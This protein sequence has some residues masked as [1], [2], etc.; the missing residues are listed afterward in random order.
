M[1]EHGAN[2][3][4]AIRHV[5]VEPASRGGLPPEPLALYRVALLSDE[6]KV[7]RIV[8][9]APNVARRAIRE[10]SGPQ[11]Q[12]LDGLTPLYCARTPGMARALLAAGADAS[13]AT[14]FERAQ[15]SPPGREEAQPSSRRRP[16]WERA[17]TPTR[18]RRTC[19]LRSTTPAGV[20]MP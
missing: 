7:K 14:S 15:A 11:A 17:L 2:L 3:L 20:V 19:A 13:A 16:S 18:A 5:G 9:A 4:P 6:A 1:G 10:P 8:A 12:L